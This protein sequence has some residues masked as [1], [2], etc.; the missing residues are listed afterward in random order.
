MT[1][2]IAATILAALLLLSGCT[3]NSQFK[4][5]TALYYPAGQITYGNS[6]DVIRVVYCEGYGRDPVDI[7]SEYLLGPTE[8]G[9]A[10]PF[11]DGTELIS[12]KQKDD[13]IT[14]VLSD[15][16]ATLSG[17]ELTKAC[18][19]LARTALGL[20]GAKTAAISCETQLI[21]GEQAL[22]ISND[23]VLWVDC[24]T[25]ISGPSAESGTNND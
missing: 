3:S 20:T 14:I 21:D 12:L 25:D 10:D 9:M 15:H 19:C 6:D 1:K 18:V 16:L 23:S 4:E 5:K 7:L 8:A 24:G 13:H 17:I 22:T 11:P 2:H